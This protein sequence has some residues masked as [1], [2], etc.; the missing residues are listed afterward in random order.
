MEDFTI[1]IYCFIDDILK[2]GHKKSGNRRKLSDSEII[3]SALISARY[4]GGNYEK[5]RKYLEEVHFFDYP[6]KSNYNRHLNRLA[7]TISSLFL[8]VGQVL[9]KLNTS[10]EY[11][12][13]SFPVAVCKNVRIPRCKLLQGEAYRGYNNS[14]KE[15]F[16]GF[17]IQ[18][19][20]TA[21]GIPVEFFISAGSYHDITAFQSMNIDLPP[22][23]K[24][25]ADKAYTDYEL[26]DY[27]K[28]LEQIDMLVIRKANSKRKDH[29][30]TDF[31][32]K[33]IRKRI[34]TSFAEMTAW[35]PKKIHA[36][37]TQGFLLKIIL[38]LFAYSF[39]RV[40]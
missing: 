2:V 30:A 28:E 37:T 17:K 6:D 14:K 12:I 36:V 40:F 35:F 9:K 15:Y 10:S 31:L 38:F 4:F 24:L 5:G 22:D 13:D 21:D 32:K 1:A 11:I 26:E 20:T 18:V 29:P 8:Q 25:Y 19:I 3:T 33:L 23:S 39:H 34:E 27:Y 7:S 16:Y